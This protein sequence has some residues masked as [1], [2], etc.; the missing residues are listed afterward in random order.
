MEGWGATQGMGGY[1]CHIG[2]IAS[3]DK[4]HRVERQEASRRATRGIAAFSR[5]ESESSGT[6]A[7]KGNLVRTFTRDKSLERRK[8]IRKQF[9]SFSAP[10]F[11]EKKN[12]EK[13]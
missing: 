3:S 12:S 6:D 10:F 1:A 11:F 8:T 13:R 9:P 5:A 4:R 2:G 7:M